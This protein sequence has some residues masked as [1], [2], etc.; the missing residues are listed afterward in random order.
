MIQY[1]EKSKKLG[2]DVRSGLLTY[3]VLM[4]ADI[5]LYQADLVPVGEDQRQHLEL[6]RDIAMRAN[7]LYG[8]RKWK[9]RGGQGGRVFK[10]PEA[11]IAP[12][13]ARIMSLTD[14]KKKMSK[15]DDQDANRVNLLDEPD[16]IFKKI[17]KC[18]TDAYQ[19]THSVRL[20]S[21]Y[22]ELIFIMLGLEFGNPDRPECNNLLGIYELVTGMSREAILEEVGGMQWGAFK[23]KLAEA[24]IEHLKPVQ[25]RFNEVMAEPS[26]LESIL[27]DGAKNASEIAE[28][29]VENCYDA[30]GFYRLSRK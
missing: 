29:T 6:T 13:G 9:K 1:K 24:V 27:K 22:T 25:N 3:P 8:G 11:F 7:Y 28:R 18:K 23:I 19:G 21:L 14:G 12:T 2:D 26:Y 4:A 15:S 10:V 5:L 17:K 16:L 20:Q 30:M